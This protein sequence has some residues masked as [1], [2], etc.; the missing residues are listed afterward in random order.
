MKIGIDVLDDDIRVEAV[1]SLCE[2]LESMGHEP[3]RAVD[4]AEWNP[5]MVFSIAGK[6]S[7]PMLISRQIETNLPFVLP[8]YHTLALLDHPLYWRRMLER[9]SV[10]VIGWVTIGPDRDPGRDTR[11]SVLGFPLSIRPISPGVSTVMKKAHNREELVAHVKSSWGEASTALISREPEEGLLRVY[12]GFV[13][14]E[15]IFRSQIDL[16]PDMDRLSRSL[17]AHI[18]EVLE[19]RGPVEIVLVWEQN[20]LFLKSIEPVLDIFENSDAHRALG[21]EYSEFLNGI[22]EA[23]MALK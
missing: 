14:G 18:A 5:D 9:E 13:S 3:R 8:P 15:Y 12:H 22:I 23:Y 19:L 16:S 21:T 2:I 11:V 4:I 1:L 20:R 10:P 6:L 17:V 7:Y